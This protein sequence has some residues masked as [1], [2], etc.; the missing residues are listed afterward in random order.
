[1]AKSDIVPIGK[2]VGVH[3]MAGNVKIYSYVASLSV[4]SPGTLLLARHDKGG[5]KTYS[6]KWAKPHAKT[7]LLSLEGIENRTQAEALVG[8]ALYIEKKS[9]PE[10]ED[11]DYYWFDLIGLSVFTLAGEYIGRVASIMPTG[12]N[13]VYIVTDVA[14]GRR[15]ETLIPAL[16]SVV[17]SIDLEQKTMQVDL[18]D[19][20]R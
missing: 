2:I 4:F 16:A 15:K 7:A 13:D 17:V 1:M 18:P 14:D 8:S 3:G 12:S 10:L 9:L 5:G 20:L 6:V 19:G 11:D